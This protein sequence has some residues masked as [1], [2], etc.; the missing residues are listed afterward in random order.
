M[1]VLKTVAFLNNKWTNYILN[2][3][4]LLYNLFLNII[5]DVEY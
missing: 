1:L 2:N 4:T 3:I 5:Q